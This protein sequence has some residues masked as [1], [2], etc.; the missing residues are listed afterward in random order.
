M[1]FQ[2]KTGHLF[3]TF[4]FLVSL[5]LSNPQI[6]QA[7]DSLQALQP[8][9]PTVKGAVTKGPGGVTTS[10]NNRGVRLNIKFGINSAWLNNRAISELNKVGQYIID[11]NLRGYLFEIEGHTC[12]IGNPDDNLVLSKNRASAVATH[13]MRNFSFPKEQFRV[14]GYGQKNPLASNATDAGRQKNR[15]VVIRN[16]NAPLGASASGTPPHVNFRMFRIK[17]NSNQKEPVKPNDIL[18]QN[19]N[20]AIEFTPERKAYVYIF[21]AD[22]NGP[23]NLFPSPSLNVRNPVNANQSYRIPKNPKQWLYLDDKQGEERIIVMASDTEIKYPMEICKQKYN[24]TF[25]QSPAAKKG[26]AGTRE[27]SKNSGIVSPYIVADKIFIKSLAFI[28]Q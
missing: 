19:D 28:H 7:E 18:T 12:N 20:Y 25:N 8:Q 26:P 9:L 13:L 10:A 21:Q 15:C 14:K 22:A 1:Q 11:K 6:C 2:I 3:I 23:T 27:D 17:A 16:T 5:I 4:Y 24:C